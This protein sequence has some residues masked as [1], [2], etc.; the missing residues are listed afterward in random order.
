MKEDESVTLPDGRILGY[1][2]YGDP[3]GKP[4]LFFHGWPS[5]RLQAAYLNDDAAKRG[6]RVLAPDR[7]GIGKSDP[8]PKRRFSDW[9]KDVAG[10]ADAL[11]LPRFSVFG[12]SGGGPYTLATC[13]SLGERIERAA[14]VCGAPP[15]A[16]ESDRTHMHW[17]Y[18]TLSGL[19][20]VRRAALPALIPLSRWMIRRGSHRAPMSWMLKSVP[21]RDR[22]AIHSGNGWD[23]VTRSYLVAV[24]N[25]PESMLTEGELYIEPWDFNPEDI[26]VP[27]RFW[28]GLADANLPCEVAKR[29][30]QRVPKSE[31]CW[32]EGEGHYS[33]AVFHST[34]VLDWLVSRQ[35]EERHSSAP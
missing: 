12:V 15:L 35:A 17:A 4:V 9:P 2:E 25:G 21:K 3:N 28:H 29:L 32:M 5:S 24:D 10:F 16:D 18:R 20:S 8:F 26:Q 6:I 13:S 34:E 1:A 30:S 27:V 22:E 31:G 33:L 19:K 14:V 7:P 11:E 23:M